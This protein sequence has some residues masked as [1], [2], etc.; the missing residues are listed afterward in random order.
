MRKIR[1]VLRLRLAGDLSIREISRSTKLSV[2]GIQKLLAR[3]TELGLAWPLPDDLDDN[4]LARLF[5]PSADTRGS[6]RF[7]MPDWPV[8]HQEL[9]R[10]HMTKQLLWEEYTQQY[11]NRCYSYSQ[12]C[13]RYQR[14][15]KQQKRSMRQHH[16][17]G[18]K[19]FVDYAGA[20]VPIVNAETGETRDAQVFVAALGAS[21]YTFAEATWTQSLPDW[22]GSHAR[23]LDYFGGCPALIVPDNLR[24]GVSKACRY[25]PDLNPS[26][27]QW[28]EHYQV[29]VVPARPYKPKDKAK[30]EV[31]V[32]VVER[33]IL[34]RLRHQTFFSLAELNQCIRVLL[35]DLN[36]RPFKQLP[37]CR[38][39]TF[40]QLDKPALRPL[41]TQPYRY[42]A[43]KPV[44][45]N[46]D[47]HVQY[48]DHH[49]SVPHPYVGERLELQVTDTL[50][51]AYFRQNLV[52]THPRKHRPGFTTNPAHMPQRHRAQQQ[53][54]PGRLKRW[55]A[56]IGPD[57]LRWVSDQLAGRE[58]REQAYRVCLGL[59]NLSKQY[60]A[61]RL[62]AACRIATAAG[63][64]RLKQ[65]RAILKS[66][67]DQLPEQLSLA[68]ALPQ[69]HENIR[70]PHNY[71]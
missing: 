69:D 49:Y 16:K 20:T 11:P 52:A 12:F 4:Q 32:Q 24:S 62:N 40:E 53:W 33:W 59:L 31:A 50:V 13:E 41:P 45:V 48:Q 27:Q 58:H 43:I 1:D 23:M 57:T 71:H 44:T 66:N 65:V 14:W 15:R 8:I 63:L 54:T 21:N 36:H 10:P 2:G 9:K 25:D 55:A 70:G 22:L 64:H 35:E 34:A 47:Y 3:T 68:Q 29:A 5:Y 56:D 19:C 28:A 46:I 37:G 60:P 42:T 38:H 30:A 18:E 17:A 39:S 26:Y 7:Q 6:R 67:R 51:E 61:A